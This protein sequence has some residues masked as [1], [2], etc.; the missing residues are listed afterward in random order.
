MLN[1]PYALLIALIALAALSSGC[2]QTRA[3]L[4]DKPRVDQD[5]PGEPPVVPVKTRK[6]IVVEVAQK[7]Q[8]LPEEKVTKET[9]SVETKDQSKVVTESR[10]T[11]VVHQDNFTFPKMTSETL[12][13]P[14]VPAATAPGATLPTQYMVQKDDTLQKISKKFYGSYGKWT[15]IYDAN[16]DKIRDPNFLKTG[17][18]LTIP[19]LPAVPAT[20]EQAGAQK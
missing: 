19:A 15:R 6:V 14:P 10:E 12:T 18:T 11:V 20:T 3:Y 2:V 8:N 17:V 13:K 7:G 4:A 16:K 1:K 5:L 9:S